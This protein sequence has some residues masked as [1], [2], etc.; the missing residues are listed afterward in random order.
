[1]TLEDEV[2]NFMFRH[3]RYITR[4]N[5]TLQQVRDLKESRIKLV[6]MVDENMKILKLID[7]IRYKSVLPLDVIIM[8]GGKGERLKPLTDNLPKPLLRVGDKP[9]LEHNLRHISNY[10]VNRV[11][12][13]VNY[14]GYMIRDYFGNGNS[15]DLNIEY[16]E[17][18]EPLGTL[19]AA[20]LIENLEYDQV[21][22]M[23]ADVLT[24]IDIEDFFSEFIEQQALMSVA[25]VPYKINMP[26]AV[27]ETAENRVLAFSEKPEYT[28]YTNAGIYLLKRDLLSRIPPNAMYHATDLMQDLLNNKEKLT[29]YSL[30]GFWMDIG[31][32]EDFQ[33]AQQEIKH[34]VIK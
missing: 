9:I 3:F 14:L 31:R 18:K 11:F 17:E 5:F 28:F 15:L 10:G 29:Q 26:F 12:I 6:P 22:V 4:N 34:L 25:S 8:A 20:A 7:L 2:E 1:L 30:H 27:L 16:V 23:N 21:L 13:C 32:K 33:R 24:N 19:G